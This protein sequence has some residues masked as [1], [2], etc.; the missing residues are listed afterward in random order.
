LAFYFVASFV[1][2]VCQG[3]YS[4]A[5]ITRV[6]K[7]GHGCGD[8][9][10]SGRCFGRQTWRNQARFSRLMIFDQVMVMGLTALK[11]PAGM[12]TSTTSTENEKSIYKALEKGEGELKVLY[13]TP[14]KI[15]KSKRF[16]SNLKN[17]TMQAAFL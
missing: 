13:V 6:W 15:S 2:L 14:E 17:A 12:L 5:E 8:P 16:M 4:G 11:I 7:A 9:H 1:F 3:C 10:A